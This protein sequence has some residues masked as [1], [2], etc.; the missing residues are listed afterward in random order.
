[1]GP[2]LLLV[3]GEPGIGKTRLAAEVA[4][5]A[6]RAGSLILYG[7]CDQE[8]AF[9]YDPFPEALAPLLERLTPDLLEHHAHALS[10]LGRQFGQRLRRWSETTPSSGVVD[11]D[12]LFAAV[13]ALVGSATAAG[14]VLVV[15]D[16]IHWA[17]R[18]GLQLI[19]HL[20]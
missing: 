18:Q 7:R 20:V 10:R 14:P 16:D 9:G 12:R 17:H 3:S 6:R 13:E 11:R 4:V 2:Q 1:Q 5:I 8:L 19:R 15:L